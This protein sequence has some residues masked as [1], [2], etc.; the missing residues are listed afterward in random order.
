MAESSVTIPK[1]LVEKLKPL[2]FRFIRVAKQGKQPIDKG[3]TK[4]ENLMSADD[5]KL[6]EWLADGGNYGVVAGRGLAILDSDTREL[7]DLTIDKLPNTFTVQSPGSKGCHSYFHSRLEKAIRLRDKDGENVGDIQGL[8]KMVVGPGSI[9]PNGRPYLIT[10]DVPLA[11]ITKEEL[12]GALKPYVVPDEEVMRIERAARSE[13][14]KA[15]LDLAITQVVLLG[16]LQRRG[17]EYFGAHPVHGSKTGRNFS[18]N[19]V[20]NCWHC[21]RHGTGGGPLSLLAV[22]EGL[23]N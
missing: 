12:L 14:S 19:A 5:P 4:P 22:Q 3:W 15:E 6:Q 20:K 18:I 13:R 1:T 9:H 2:G 7:I 11:K 17:D 16:K 21:F 10:N 23:I 8:G